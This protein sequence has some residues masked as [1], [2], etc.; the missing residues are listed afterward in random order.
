MI[1]YSEALDRILQTDYTLPLERLPLNQAFNRI[2]AEAITSPEN[3]PSFNNSAMDGFAIRTQD[4]TQTLNVIGTIAAGNRLTSIIK[5]KTNTAW[6]I[7]TGAPIPEGYDA[8]VK[9]EDTTKNSSHIQLTR[10]VK[11]NENIR[12]AGEDFLTNDPVI[13]VGEKI[14]SAHV[15][16]LAALGINELSVKEK[17]KITLI[18]TGDE[19]I[20]DSTASLSFGKIRNSNSPY[21]RTLLPLLGA[22]I[23]AYKT[24]KDDKHDFIRMIEQVTSDTNKPTIIVTTGGVSA[25]RWDIIPAALKE[26]GANIIFHKAKI[27]PGKPILFAKLKNTFIIGLPGNPIASAAGARFF[28]YPLIR[29]MLGQNQEEPISAILENGTTKKSEFRFFYKA[30]YHINKNSEVKATLLTGQESFKMSPLLK[31]NCWAV[32][33]EG[34][35]SY[36]PTEKITIYPFI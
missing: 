30:L 10:S 11:K 26:M 27:R 23:N 36:Q 34:R 31:A 7:M 21:L 14:T 6:E 32:L 13:N 25:G 29:K 18:S 15:M 8:V 28:I 17:P 1:S 4:Q 5:D 22:D 24:C 2:N 20:K 12:M 35:D 19:L 3:L 9:V 16:A 33:E